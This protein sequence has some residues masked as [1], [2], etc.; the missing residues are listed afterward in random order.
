MDK[1]ARIDRASDGSFMR[2]EVI[3][4]LKLAC[5]SLTA[6]LVVATFVI[7]GFG[8]APPV[9]STFL[10]THPER[11]E[12]DFSLELFH[13]CASNLSISTTESSDRVAAIE[14][15]LKLPQQT[16]VPI[17]VCMF[18]RCQQM[19]DEPFISENSEELRVAHYSF[20]LDGVDRKNR[21][22]YV[23]I[24]FPNDNPDKD[25]AFSVTV[26]PRVKGFFFN[27]TSESESSIQ[28]IRDVAQ[29]TFTV[30]C[31]S[32]TSYCAPQYFLRFGDI[33]YFHYQ[34]DVLLNSTD[35][36][37]INGTDVLFHVTKGTREFTNW[38]IGV[39]LFFLI[40]S[41]LM[42]LW[43]NL[44]LNRLSEREQNM[45][46]IWVV[47]LGIALIAFNDPFYFAEANFGVDSIKLI[48]VVFQV[49]FFQLL[50]LFWLVALD[51][52][53]LQGK[54]QGVSD[55]AFFAPKVAFT[56]FFWLVML[57]LYGFKKYFGN[58][59]LAW[60]P[61]EKNS[62]FTMLKAITGGLSLWYLG[63]F[64][65]LILLSRHEIRAKKPRYRILLMLSFAVVLVSFL[66]LGAGTFSP[67]PSS[68]GEWT[69]FQA[70]FNSYVFVLSYLFAPSATTTAKAKQRM[71][72]SGMNTPPEA[73][74]SLGRP[75]ADE[76]LEMSAI[77]VENALN[78]SEDGAIHMA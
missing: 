21:Y 50:L 25:H 43:Y 38:M 16:Q 18:D 71:Q 60:D 56:F 54:E 76:N 10:A 26:T 5:L 51:N 17:L 73:A 41:S 62:T 30:S 33:A 52:L 72:M 3:S 63:W 47:A 44:A 66:G 35:G 15:L 8:A 19:T 2:I 59:D 48:G 37:P 24:Q 14:E 69:S 6:I 75:E 11:C 29:Q 61:L 7:I 31:S 45:E 49:S 40:T 13:E 23:D 58:N 57:V 1:M 32:G 34:I 70:I 74:P 67:T 77:D 53:R 36:L 27:D 9:S 78:A 39:K 12:A 55:T 4:I 22:M 68:G 28:V 65:H 46:Q 20:G 64:F 42:A